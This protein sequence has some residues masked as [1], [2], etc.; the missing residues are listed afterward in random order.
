MPMK[1]LQLIFLKETEEDKYCR[2]D[3]EGVEVSP[4]TFMD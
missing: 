1:T 3:L 4:T 2:D